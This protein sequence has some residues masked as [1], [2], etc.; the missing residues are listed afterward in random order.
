MLTLFLFAICVWLGAYLLN[1]RPFDATGLLHSAAL[2]LSAMLLAGDATLRGDLALQPLWALPAVVCIGFGIAFHIRDARRR[3][4]AVWLP[5]IR[6]LDGAMITAALFGLQIVLFA[7]VVP[8]EA[9]A[10]AALNPLLFGVVAAAILIQTLS[11]RIQAAF[12]AFAFAHLPAFTR[13]RIRQARTD[14]REAI[15]E[16]PKAQPS[17]ADLAALDDAEFA[18]LTR[19]ALSSM[20]DLPKLAASPL[21][22]LPIID[23]RLAQR[24]AHRDALER[25]VELK[26]LLSEMIGRLKP[27][28]E[29]AFGTSSEWRH[30]NALYFPYVAGLK[31]YARLNGEADALEPEQREAIAW[32]QR[33]VPERTLYNWQGAAARLIAQELR[34][35][36][37]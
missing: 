1:R 29:A 16:I 15:D 9:S 2:A 6:A 19:R 31:P 22:E 37:Q 10:R 3:E 30:Y 32:F 12:D 24:G 8:M 26:R 28:G 35:T 25:T 13:Q 21:I 34:R 27:E 17:S 11:G 20:G 36:S 7:A 18:R 5:L 4:E 14:L 23:H 33:E